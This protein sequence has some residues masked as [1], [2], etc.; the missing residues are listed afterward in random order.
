MS[1]PLKKIKD[2]I[3]NVV[4]N[5]RWSVSTSKLATSEVP[6]I[7]IT[8]Y[9]QSTSSMI[10][11]MS[12]YATQT[13]DSINPGTLS[14]DPYEKLYAVDKRE[15]GN[16]YILPYYSAYHHYIENR[17][18]E[19]K[20]TISQMAAKAQSFATD[21]TKA[22]YPSANIE[23]AYSW[24]GSTPATYAFSFQLLNTVNPETD[25]PENRTFI[26]T[27]LHNNLF[28]KLNIIAMRPPAICTIYIP[29]IRELT[30]GILSNIV[31]ENFGQ[32]NSMKLESESK[33]VNIP[34]AYN[35]TITVQELLL[36][37]RQ[38]L[39]GV[40]TDKESGKVFADIE[41]IK[42]LVDKATDKLNTI[43]KK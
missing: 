10:Q 21:L 41:D 12:Y 7:E 42:T 9:Q 38:I 36:E 8:E 28:D 11:A 32:V 17:W 29:G 20:G 19:N 26:N 3:V 14:G 1:L 40:L 30:I 43:G 34:D 35:I 6:T 18:G 4:E 24:E 23:A 37:S 16:M 2:G 27:L 25:I 39:A 33:K 13:I 15:Q 5:Y 22:V 31:I